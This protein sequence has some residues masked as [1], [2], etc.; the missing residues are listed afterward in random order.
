MTLIT[1]LLLTDVL[2]IAATLLSISVFALEE[3][4]IGVVAVLLKWE[5]VLL[6]GLALVW[7][8]I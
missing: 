1:K 5:M 3:K 7:L 4:G 2:A 6:I 8:W